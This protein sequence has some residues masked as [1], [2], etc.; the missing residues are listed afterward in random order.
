VPLARSDIETAYRSYGHSVL[1]RARRILGRDDEAQEVLQEVFTSLL[2]AP[3]Q[4]AGRSAVSSWLY[5]AATHRCL[6]RLRNQRTRRR[7]LNERVVP[8]ADEG[9]EASPESRG[10][11]ARILAGLPDEQATAVIHYYIDEM[12][13]AEI[14]ELMGCSRRHVGNL[15]ERSRDTLE[16]QVRP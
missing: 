1:R 14:A 12:T 2:D 9:A 8:L 10:D 6:N 4:F 7:L 11:L 16:R 5:G 13:H 3:E 15:L